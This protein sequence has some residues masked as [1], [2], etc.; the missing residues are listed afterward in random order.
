MH[1]VCIAQIS[2]KLCLLLAG[3]Y[4]KL[5]GVHRPVAMKKSTIKRRKRVIPFIHDQTQTSERSPHS[6]VESASPEASRATVVEL[7]EH[8]P[9]PLTGDSS[10]FDER[11]REQLERL[12]FDPPPVDFTDYHVSRG[13]DH[14]QKQPSPLRESPDKALAQSQG[15]SQP[16]PLLEQ[17]RKRRRSV[18][19]GTHVEQPQNNRANI[20]RLS[21]ISSILNPP[22]QPQQQ[23]HQQLGANEES[24][25]DPDLP[26]E[27]PPSH[28]YHDQNLQPPQSQQQQQRYMQESGLQTTQPKPSDH[29]YPSGIDDSE[30]R[31]AKLRQ[32]AESLREMLRAKEREL[33]ELG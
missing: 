14:I 16:A 8:S 32:E 24:P 29:S 12:R 5:H 30:D 25:I 23:S 20:N 18:A 6:M 7:Q 3:L 15:Q 1:A 26:H 9:G 27:V 17:S 2:S 19:E 21:S 22:Q 11:P 13:G 28:S 31:R 33:K 10:N 4:H